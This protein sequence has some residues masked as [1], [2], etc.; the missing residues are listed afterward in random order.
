[1]EIGPIWPMIFPKH[2]KPAEFVIGLLVLTRSD[3]LIQPGKLGHRLF[4]GTPNTGMLTLLIDFSG[5]S[6]QCTGALG[7]TS[8]ES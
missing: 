6:S 3:Q 1:M 5:Q 7:F 2:N 4:K 8:Q